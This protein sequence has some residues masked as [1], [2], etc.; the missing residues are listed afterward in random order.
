MVLLH[1][2]HS[3]LRV[4]TKCSTDILLVLDGCKAH[5]STGRVYK[6]M[7]L[8]VGTIRTG[9]RRLVRKSDMFRSCEP[10]GSS[11]R[12]AEG[13]MPV[14]YQSRIKKCKPSRCFHR[15]RASMLV[16]KNIGISM[17]KEQVQVVNKQRRKLLQGALVFGAATATP[18]V[19]GKA[20]SVDD[21]VNIS[22]KLI[23]KMNDSVKTLILKNHS[24]QELTI[25]RI[26]GSAFMY[27][28]GIV[29]CNGAFVSKSIR[30]PANQEVQIQFDKLQQ[31][32]V[33]HQIDEIRRVQSRVERLSDGTRVIP[34][35]ATVREWV[36][37]VV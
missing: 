11:A 23:C 16:Q 9:G 4:C 24:D 5:L 13:A 18:A 3:A 10:R 19:I 36:A 2:A 1:T 35:T 15:F 32:S 20:L 22:G 6:T 25:V 28:G 26:S 33:S 12:S 17:N 31:F 34:F 14:K 8:T 29:D 30:I 7:R 27:D 37:T 21:Q